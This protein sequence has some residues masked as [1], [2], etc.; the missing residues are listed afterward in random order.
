MRSTPIVANTSA[1][2]VAK[3]LRRV[4]LFSALFVTASVS[5]WAQNI[6]VSPAKVAFAKTIVGVTS[7]PK[8]VT[9][10]NKSASAQAVNFV[11]SGD[12]SETDNCSG[13]VAAGHSCKANISFTPTMVG[14]ISGATGVYDNS[15]NLLAFVGLSGTGGPPVTTTP[16]SLSFTSG[17]I[18]TQSAAKTFNITNNTS[19]AVNITGITTNVTDYQISTGTCLM[20]PL[21]AAGNCTVS[22]QVTPTSA[23][24]DGAIII[25][26][27]APSA[28][29]LVVKLTSTA[30]AGTA[31]ISL[32][33]TSLTFTVAA[34]GTSAAQTVTVK[35]NSSAVGDIGH[36]YGERGLC[37]LEH[38]VQFLT[39]SE[40]EVHHQHRIS[41]DVCWND[42]GNGCGSLYHQ[43]RQQPAGRQFD[44]YFGISVD[45]FSR[46]AHLRV[47]VSR[48]VGAAKSATVTNNS[49]AL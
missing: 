45:G 48:H 14:S 30:K 2:S 36:D 21:A 31:P 35:N 15:N 42:R 33:K 24:D 44:G 9:I 39:G 29:P 26:D 16:T 34:G 38:D 11:T 17:T 19:T 1:S 3:K 13:S 32:S 41:A 7:S 49:A 40:G 5:S 20:T 6:T 12:F 27:D 43:Q 23:V 46:E 18:G 22:V 4:L 25:T 28:V 8:I 10:T 37:D 47:A